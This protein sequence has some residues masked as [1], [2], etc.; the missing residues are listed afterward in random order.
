MHFMAMLG[1]DVVGSPVRFDVGYTALSA[2]AAVVVVGAGLLFVG[3]GR[4]TAIK[5]IV[6]GFFTGIGVAGMHYLGTAALRV[7]GDIQHDQSLVIAS[8]VIAVVAATVA[9]WFTVI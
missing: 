1:F 3:L 2:V 4:P 7:N 5:I 6:G 9:L 8:I